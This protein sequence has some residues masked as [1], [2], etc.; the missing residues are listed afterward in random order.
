MDSSDFVEQMDAI[1]TYFKA[2][3][4]RAALQGS[5]ALQRDVT[6][7]APS[8]ATQLGW[9]TFF[10]VR[11]LHALG[12]DL[13]GLVAMAR[14]DPARCAI[15]AINRAYLHSLAAEMAA[16]AGRAADVVEH[17]RRCLALRTGDDRTTCARTMCHLLWQLGR[18]DLNREFA[19]HLAA[20]A[21]RDGLDFL[22]DNLEMTGAADVHADAER[23]LAA[24]PVDE[25]D[26][27][28]DLRVAAL[29]GGHRPAAEAATM[30]IVQACGRP[31]FDDGSLADR[32]FVFGAGARMPSTLARGAAVFEIDALEHLVSADKPEL[33]G[34]HTTLVYQH[35]RFRAFD[36]PAARRLGEALRRSPCRRLCLLFTT[37]A[38]G[39]LRELA[40]VALAGRVTGSM[41]LDALSLGWYFCADAITDEASHVADVVDLAVRLQPRRLALLTG[42]W[43]EAVDAALAAGLAA[44]PDLASFDALDRDDA[45]TY[46]RLPSEHVDA[47]LRGRGARR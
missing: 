9:A 43:S 11:A 32:R 5:R 3:E 6:S 21:P 4:H 13:E 7:A 14:I 29:A 2:G 16:R 46:P 27:L 28:L 12:R 22:L 8:D 37:I 10:E 40:D 38:P 30:M 39:A 15:E 17:G 34:R 18:G 41:A 33:V 19:L 24:V 47:L 31:W 35:E 25:R 36:V 23:V 26:E 45:N 42:K 1:S 20:A 44:A